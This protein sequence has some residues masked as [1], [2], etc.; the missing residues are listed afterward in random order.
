MS[1]L[2]IL[3][4]SRTIGWTIKVLLR[5]VSVSP[6]LGHSL[7]LQDL[8]GRHLSFCIE[9]ICLR[10]GQTEPHVRVNKLFWNCQ[11]FQIE[12]AQIVSTLAC[13]AGVWNVLGGF[14]VPLSALT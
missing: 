1:Q 12:K 13:A 5:R 3:R 10:A 4:L 9:K 6:L 8:S 7:S 2:P 14:T 11:T